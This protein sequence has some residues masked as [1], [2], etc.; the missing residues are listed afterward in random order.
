MQGRQGGFDDTTT[1]TGFN[2]SHL[3]DNSFCQV[4]PHLSVRN[5]DSSYGRDN[6]LSSGANP[7]SGLG[8]DEFSDSSNYGSTGR[9]TLR[10]DLEER[11]TLGNTLGRDEYSGGSH[12]PGS[13]TGTNTTT[14]S[15][16]LGNDYTTG[17]STGYGESTGDRLRE[18][19]GLGSDRDNYGSNTYGSN[20][21]SGLTGT[22]EYGSQH[23]KTTGD[24]I[25]EPLREGE[26]MTN[27]GAHGHEPSK[28]SSGNNRDTNEYDSGLTNSSGL[29]H[30]TT[31]GDRVGEH[32]LKP[33][34]GRERDTHHSTFGNTLDGVSVHADC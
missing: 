15:S 29:H 19:T 23:H 22:S 33:D 1:G 27:M 16:G 34:H 21:G 4:N 20:A 10:E 12:V 8:R 2:V 28:F 32:D 5:Q 11:G 14:H 6:N 26:R 30:T 25:K 7:G 31:A 24:K 3:L 17:G 9:G 13:H 18:S